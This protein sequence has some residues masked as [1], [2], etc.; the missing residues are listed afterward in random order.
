MKTFPKRA[1]VAALPFACLFASGAFADECRFGADRS[2]RIDGDGIRKV[3]VLARAGDLEIY[4]EEGTTGVVAKGKACASSQKDL[5]AISIEGR[6]EGDTVYV[7]TVLPESIE[8]V[9]A[10]WKYDAYLDLIVTVPKSAI[11]SVEDSSGDLEVNTVQEATI[12]DSSGD[13]SVHGIAGNLHITD[14]SGEINIEQV[15]GNVRLSDS[16]GDMDVR[17]VKGSVEVTVD[18]SGDIT[19]EKV[20]GEVH[21]LHDSSGDIEIADV[22]HNVTIDSDSSG[23][24][25]V[26]RIGGDFTVGADGSGEIVHERV[27]GAVHLPD[28]N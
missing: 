5:D 17:D 26:D 14:S 1:L 18:S 16:S 3:V 8:R 25:H 6:R 15:G 22:Q 2:A 23:G 7:K 13:Q 24:I 4:G 20:A 27:L 21:I 12:A 28:D 19:I 9:F 10:F 11:L